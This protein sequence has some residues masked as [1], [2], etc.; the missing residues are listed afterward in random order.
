VLKFLQL[1][2]GSIVARKLE[3]ALQV[4]DDGIQRTVLVIGGAAKL[5]ARHPRVRELLCELLHKPG[6]ANPGLTAEQHHLAFAL[7]GFFPPF[8]QYSHFVP[9]PDEGRQAGADGHLKATLRRALP[10]DLVH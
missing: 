9:T 1:G 8:P 6:F 3:E 7:P 2:G 10:H 5:K 4:V